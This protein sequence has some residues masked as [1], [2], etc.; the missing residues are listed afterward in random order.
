MMIFTIATPATT[1]EHKGY[2]GLWPVTIA[3]HAKTIENLGGNNFA[4]AVYAMMMEHQ[5]Y[6]YVYETPICNGN[7]NTNIKY[8]L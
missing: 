8:Q 6:N 1:L 4:S 3:I 7:L 2:V 5:G